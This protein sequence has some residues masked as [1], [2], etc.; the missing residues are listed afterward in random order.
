MKNLYLIIVLSFLLVGC[1]SPPTR[2]VQ[3]AEVTE[4]YYNYDSL[5]SGFY[6]D[7]SSSLEKSTQIELNFSV[8]P[9]YVNYNFG[10]GY[11]YPYYVFGH[12]Y[13]YYY[14]GWN[15]PYLYYYG[16]SYP[17]MYP[18]G[19]PYYSWYHQI[20]YGRR[21]EYW[22]GNRNYMNNRQKINILDRRKHSNPQTSP[23]KRNNPNYVRPNANRSPGYVRPQ[24]R[25][26]NY[27]IPTSETKRNIGTRS[28]QTQSYSS[29]VYRQ[30]KTSR[31]Y[32]APRRQSQNTVQ[33]G[34]SVDNTNKRSSIRFTSPVRNV[35]SDNNS[36]S[37]PIQNFGSIPARNSNP[38]RNSSGVRRK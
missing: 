12:L 17:W 10:Y 1:S 32:I 15:Y 35:K 31:D 29:P 13:P 6:N 21:Y 26:K 37:T 16:W 28:E 4:E 33:S 5:P 38:A 19:Y 36:F 11:V 14:G 9:S 34:N 22:K 24:Q 25:T 30:P 8:Y 27:S 18:L 20:Y 23:N 3:K 2:I 7:Y